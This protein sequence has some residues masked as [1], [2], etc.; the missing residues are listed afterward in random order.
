[1]YPPQE[2]E[3]AKGGMARGVQDREALDGHRP[4]G[5]APEPHGV[6][7]GS[8]ELTDVAPAGCAGSDHD[9]CPIALLIL[10]THGVIVQSSG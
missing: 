9:D 5:G 1:M 4:R 8:A 6:P 2:A 3:I 10:L 7:A